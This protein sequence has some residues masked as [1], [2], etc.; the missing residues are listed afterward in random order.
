[1]IISSPCCSCCVGSSI[2]FMHDWIDRSSASSSKVPETFCC[3]ESEVVSCLLVDLVPST[4]AAVIV[5]VM[6]SDNNDDDGGD[7]D[8]DDRGDKGSLLSLSTVL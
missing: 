5:V 1:M 8:D 7:D 4:A 3:R 2:S 6:P